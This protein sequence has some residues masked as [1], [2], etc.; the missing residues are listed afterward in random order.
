MDAPSLQE[1]LQLELQCVL[2]RY[3][4]LDIL[5]LQDM[6]EVLDTIKLNYFLQFS[7]SMESMGV[8]QGIGT[9]TRAVTADPSESP[10]MRDMSKAELNA[11]EPI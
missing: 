1:C 3:Q 4:M 8:N 2:D 6:V 10:H 5:G 9:Q 7:A 11:E